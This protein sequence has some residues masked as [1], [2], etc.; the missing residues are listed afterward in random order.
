MDLGLSVLE[1]W[2]MSDLSGFYR[3]DVLLVLGEVVVD[4]VNLV[5]HDGI[6]EVEKVQ[7]KGS[8]EG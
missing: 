6:L 3:V 7:G 4:F 5:G 1:H 2:T 8:V